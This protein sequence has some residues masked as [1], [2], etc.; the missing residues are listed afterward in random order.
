M[1][2]ANFFRTSGRLVHGSPLA[3]LGAAVASVVVAA[4]PLANGQDSDA[5]SPRRAGAP[6]SL[7]PTFEPPTR[8]IVSFTDNRVELE[9]VGLTMAIPS[10]G[11]ALVQTIGGR[12][13]AG[14]ILGDDLG[15]ILMQSRETGGGTLSVL[16]L[17]K[18]V[19]RRTLFRTLSDE[20]IELTIDLLVETEAGI[21][22]GRSPA[23]PSA[24]RILRPFYVRMKEETPQPMRGFGVIPIDEETFVLFQL[25]C[26]DEA[27]EK[28]RQV[29]ELCLESARLTEGGELD[30]EREALIARGQRVLDG[31]TTEAMRAIVSD[32]P[33]QFERIYRPA[34]GGAVADEEEV[35]YR[36]VRAW[37][38][39][40]RDVETGK[41][42]PKG[43]KTGFVLRVDGSVLL[44][45]GFGGTSR[46]DSRAVYY[47]SEDRKQESWKVDM[48]IHTEGAPKPEIWSE[49]G[50][51]LGDSMSVQ[52][53]NSNR[54]SS[55]IRPS[56]R[57]DGYVSRLEAYLMP[58]LLIHAEAEGEFAFYA[59]D[60]T[61]EVNRLRT[62]N[63]SRA[64]DRPGLWRVRTEL[65]TDQ[66]E[67]SEFNEYGRLIRSETSD[68]LV[69][70]PIEFE[71]L[72]G[73]WNAKG[74]P[75]D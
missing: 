29:F 59:Y 21:S 40:V 37:L 26:S 12:P 19:L 68:G 54:D 47:L 33:D 30:A 73:I 43:A 72:Y 48:S 7:G 17:E 1:G 35:G 63:A 61:A 23:V 55:T 62:V 58:Q 41:E 51:R 64:A 15:T 38:G 71:R 65:S 50:M 5:A 13:T 69:K 70:R 14:I 39:S 4:A 56:I 52:I 60:Q 27:F 34:P 36:R 8:D 57:G 46:A 16:D 3:W 20:R 31:I 22:L 11:E 24:G 42:D 28:A 75:L 9:T 10:G 49:M 53:T 18:A 74:L 2:F 67:A 44:D 66:W 6:T 32:V 25:I 45:D